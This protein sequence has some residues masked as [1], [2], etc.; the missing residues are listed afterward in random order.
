MDMCTYVHT[1][2]H[3]NRYTNIQKI[4]AIS[5]YIARRMHI[6]MGMFKRILVYMPLN[7]TIYKLMRGKFLPSPRKTATQGTL[8]VYPTFLFVF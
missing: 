6:N 4:M 1:Q 2:M 8:L 3:R 7:I 5:I